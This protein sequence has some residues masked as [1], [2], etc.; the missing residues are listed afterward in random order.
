ME[1]ITD[2][3]YNQKFEIK[4]LGQHHDL[5]LKIDTLRLADVFEDLRKMCLESHEL[6]PSNIYFRSRIS[7]ASSFKKDQSKIRI[8][9]SY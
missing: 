5:Y 6:D 4:N 1:D 8:I 9:N 2:S 7:V 3:D